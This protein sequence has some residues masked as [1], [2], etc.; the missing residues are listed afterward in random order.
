MSTT[1]LLVVLW[2]RSINIWKIWNSQKGQETEFIE[3]KQLIEAR[4]KEKKKYFWVESKEQIKLDFKKT[5]K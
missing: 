5:N 3:E 2:P 4:K 1:L